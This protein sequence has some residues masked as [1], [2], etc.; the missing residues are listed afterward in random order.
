M[1]TD[2]KPPSNGA[3]PEDYA[4]LGATLFKIGAL[5]LGVSVAVYVVWFGA[6]NKAPPG[7]PDSW[8]QLGDFLG[9]VAGTIIALLTL[10]AIG[11]AIKLQ[12]TEFHTM[13][14]A[15]A[16]Q[17]H[18]A[19]IEG[20]ESTFFQVLD[21]L[22]N[23]TN[24]P[25]APVYAKGWVEN[26]GKETKVLAAGESLVAKTRTAYQRLFDSHSPELGPYFRTLYF[27][28][29]FIDKA[30]ALE[31]EQKYRYAK[32]VRAQFSSHELVLIFLNVVCH[33]EGIKGLRPYVE[34]YSLLKHA[35]A[36]DDPPALVEF[37][38]VEA[39]IHPRAFASSEQRR[40]AGW[41]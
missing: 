10:W 21:R 30:P 2:S 33:E 23:M 12:Q 22:T 4:A 41:N 28:M 39:F 24:G 18:A 31:D 15:L 8:G 27:L 32:L 13:H 5:T 19:K 35:A 7:Q 11:Q 1:S 26:I 34:R 14:A 9:G 16:E 38:K 17:S 37:R 40:V 6:V 3:R 36:I 29:E 20:F 25:N